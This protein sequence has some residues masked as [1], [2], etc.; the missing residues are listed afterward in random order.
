MLL[1]IRNK[2]A[3]VK[4]KYLHK[5][6]A[7]CFNRELRIAIYEKRQVHQIK[8]SKQMGAYSKEIL[9]LCDCAKRKSIQNILWKD[10]HGDRRQKTIGWLWSHFLSKKHHT[11]KNHTKSNDNMLNNVND[12]SETFNSFFFNVAKDLGKDEYFCQETEA[13]SSILAITENVS[14][15]RLDFKETK[16]EAVKNHQ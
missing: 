9:W 10:V 13:H 7:P 16:E 12:D 4:Y 14:D 6:F 1:Q 3:P 2:H 11:A 5:T 8:K 15:T